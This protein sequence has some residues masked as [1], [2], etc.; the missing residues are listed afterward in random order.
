MTL[1]HECDSLAND[2]QTATV[3]RKTPMSHLG[4][5]QR[6]DTVEKKMELR[7]TKVAH[8]MVGNHWKKRPFCVEK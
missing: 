4:S 1:R 7:S 5:V 3:Q 6:N 2:N 8:R